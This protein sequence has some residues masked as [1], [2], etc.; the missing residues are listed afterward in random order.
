[1][2]FSEAARRNSIGLLLKTLTRIQH[3]KQITLT[4][5]LTNISLTDYSGR[6]VLDAG[7]LGNGGPAF[8]NGG[9]SMFYL[10]SS[11]L[12]VR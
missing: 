1:M 10:N 9:S 4:C 8:L 12:E 3:F 11:L 2:M 7:A 5:C 6:K